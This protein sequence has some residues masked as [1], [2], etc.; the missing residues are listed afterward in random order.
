MIGYSGVGKGMGELKT[1]LY[2]DREPWKSFLE[3]ARD[4]SSVSH[5]TKDSAPCCFVHGMFDCGIQVPMG[6]S[7]RMFEALTRAGVKSLCLLN[8]QGIYGQDPEVQQAM[9]QFLTLRV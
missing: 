1:H 8:N 6:Q 5:V 9:L 2:D 4:A 7:L 3:L